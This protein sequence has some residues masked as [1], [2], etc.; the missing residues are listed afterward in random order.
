M[1]VP[2]IKEIDI[3]LEKEPVFKN[4]LVEAHPEVC[5]T[6]LSLDRRV[7]EPIYENKKTEEGIRK[8]LELLEHYYQRTADV[9][10][11]LHNHPIF[12]KMVD[13]VVDALCLAVVGLQGDKS[14]LKSIPEKP[15]KDPKGLLMQMVFAE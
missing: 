10:E 2:K 5:F 8:R 15:S 4:V 6:M 9:S 11:F 7:K 13:D 14:K 3:F 12:S 1:I